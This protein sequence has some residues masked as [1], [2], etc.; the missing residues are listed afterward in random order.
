MEPPTCGPD[1]IWEATL[2]PY[3][4]PTVL[5]A[6]EIGLFARLHER[7]SSIDEVALQYGMRH[8]CDLPAA[9]RPQGL[10]GYLPSC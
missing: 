2:A 7:P 4:L 8:H 10:T 3:H 6:D 1:A 5:V 9:D